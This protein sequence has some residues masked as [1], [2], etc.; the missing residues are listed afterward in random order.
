MYQ[1]R[2]AT[3]QQRLDLAHL[4]RGQCTAVKPPDVV[5]LASINANHSHYN[6][7]MTAPAP[8]LL[9]STVPAA[10]EAAAAAAAPAPVRWRSEELL[11]HQPQVEID[12]AGQIYRLRV[13]AQGK[14]ILTK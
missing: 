5:G 12:H 4:G 6:G 11:R 3:D 8:P 9:A 2:L 14:L 10:A 13:T 7:C 1:G